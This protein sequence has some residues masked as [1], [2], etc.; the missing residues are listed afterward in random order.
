MA[1]AGIAFDGNDNNK[2]VGTK[3][4]DAFFFLVAAINRGAPS[5][6][7][8]SFLAGAHSL[9]DSFAGAL[10]YRTSISP[11]AHDGVAVLATNVFEQACTCFK[12][13]GDLRRL[14]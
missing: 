7:R 11:S 5:V 1:K 4:C 14:R 6:T 9:G 3:T 13:K 8:D 2:V 10:T 12:Y